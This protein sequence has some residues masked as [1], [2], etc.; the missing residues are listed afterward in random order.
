MMNK[1][2]KGTIFG[3]T[4]PRAQIPNLLSMYREGT[5]KLDELVTNRYTLDQ[6]NDGYRDMR[7]G[8]NH[9]GVLPLR[10]PCQTC[11]LERDS[12]PVGTSAPSPPPPRGCGAAPR[13]G[14]T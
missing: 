7:E 12:G 8:K 6:I 5:L 11:S 2:V 4:N 14:R 9:R 3:S 13:A 1:E 10:C